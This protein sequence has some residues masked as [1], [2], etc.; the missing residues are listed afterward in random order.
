MHTFGFEHSDLYRLALSIHRR[1][2]KLKVPPGFGD[3][4]SQMRRA[5]GSMV[6]NSAEGWERGRGKAAQNH[7]RIARASAAETLACLD[8]L[9]HQDA[10][11]RNDLRRVGAMTS[12]LAR[13]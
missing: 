2:L 5:S 1:I 3:L 13:S 8:I 10:T 6:L 4:G 9:D 7:F 11:I 12:K